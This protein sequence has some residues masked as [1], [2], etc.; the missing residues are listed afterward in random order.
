MNTKL[1]QDIG[2]SK[3]ETKVYLALLKIGETTTGPLAKESEVS[4]SKVYKILDKLIKKGLV[5]HIINGSTKYF[6]ALNP[7]RILEYMDQKEQD[8]K[9][10]K[11]E[12]EKLIPTREAER[13]AVKKPKAAV[14]EGFKAITNFFKNILDDLEK[15]EEYYV[16]GA[17]YAKNYPGAK[18][19]FHNYHRQRVKKGIKVKMLGNHETKDGLK[20]IIYKDSE[21]RYLPQKF[22]SNMQI[23]FYKRKAFI[24]IW[25]AKYPTAF[26][27]D[28]GE[29]ANSFKSYFDTLWKISKK[30]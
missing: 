3:G 19:F 30:E 8:L 15:G 1:F 25:E 11:S 28:S 4:A 17:N 27:V 21:I 22:V 5:G 2:F 7:R 23:T 14:F 24:I 29:A 6:S 10:K 13:E 26:L 9:Q 18:E 20:K 16:I 12:I